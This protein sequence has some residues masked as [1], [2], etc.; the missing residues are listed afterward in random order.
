MN[1]TAFFK[2]EFFGGHSTCRGPLFLGHTVEGVETTYW[3]DVLQ[4]YLRKTRVDK[5]LYHLLLTFEQNHMVQAEYYGIPTRVTKL[6]VEPKV[7]LRT[8]EH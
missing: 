7:S 3:V 4:K 8:I 2:T 6:K 1:I 5:Y